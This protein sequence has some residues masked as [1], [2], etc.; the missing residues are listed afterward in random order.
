MFR[1]FRMMTRHWLRRC[2]LAATLIGL[3]AGRAAAQGSSDE[4][5]LFLLLPVGADA[6]SMGRAV[7]AMPGPESA[8]WNPAGLATI[9]RSQLVLARGSGPAGV[10]TSASMLFRRAG[11]GTLG[12]SYLLLDLGEQLN[13]DF[14]N[15]VLGTIS[16]R[17]HLAVVSAA[18]EVLPGLD[19]GVNFKMFEFRRSCR[20]SCTDVGTA[21]VGYAM[22]AGVQLMPI[23]GVPLR[24]GAMVAHLGPRFQLQNAA[25]SDPLPTRIRVAA[26]YDVLHHLGRPGLQGW[27][28]AELQDR[29]GYQGGRSLYLGSEIAAGELDVLYLRMGYITGAERPGG[30]SVGLGLWSG[31]Y[32]VSVAKSLTVSSLQGTYDPLTISFSLGF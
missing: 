25:Q 7:T 1:V 3:G 9:D 26:A 16:T 17:N 6:I 19:A 8:F 15:N 28:T 5:A 32:G 20:G 14:D 27:V 30:A 24:L 4:G 31:K 2:A 13:T 22:D 10:S 21:S 29:P 18:A 12:I 11:V 23:R